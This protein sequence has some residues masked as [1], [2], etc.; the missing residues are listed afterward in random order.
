[1]KKQLLL[2]AIIVLSV[3][4]L[5]SLSKAQEKEKNFR[6]GFTATPTFGWMDFKSGYTPGSNGD[7]LRT[8]FSYGVLGDFGFS[9]NY[10]FSSGFLVTT[11]NSKVKTVASN[12]GPGSD[13]SNAVYKLQYLEL[14]LTLKLKTDPGKLVRFYGQFGL[15]TGIT[16]GA[17]RDFKL[18]SNGIVTADEKN[19]SIDNEKTF[20]LSLIAG[21]GAEWN[22]GANTSILTGVTLNNGFTDVF[23]NGQSARNSYVA[24]NLALYF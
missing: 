21:A 6:L 22:I 15:G 8:G 4:I 18:T 11:I 16:I 9:K 1:M 5:P 12:S 2:I 13:I 24:L 17:K 3:I 19:V 10:Y 14:P 23:S 20:R 7:G